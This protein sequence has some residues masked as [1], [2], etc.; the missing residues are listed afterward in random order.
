MSG[1]PDWLLAVVSPGERL[2]DD[3]ALMAR[4]IA[5][6]GANLEHTGG[7]PFG[8][9]VADGDRRVVGIGTNLVV[10][11]HDSTA[12]AEIMALRRA[13]EALESYSL[14]INGFTLYTSA[15]PCLMCAAALGWA[16]VPRVVAAARRADVE[17]LGFI[18]GPSGFDAADVLRNAGIVYEA[19]CLRDD[20][21]ALLGRYSGVIYN[22]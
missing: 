15:A 16:G 19:D 21:V 9:V 10:P 22:G 13:E 12:H 17:A 6:G 5:V 14:R 18:E 1:Y 2:P 7:G 4:A 8:A 20:A 3:A 11:T